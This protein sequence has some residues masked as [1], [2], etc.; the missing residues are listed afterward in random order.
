MPSGG[1]EH[2]WTAAWHSD[3]D[4]GQYRD[5]GTADH[6]RLLALKDN[7]TGR[8]A[9]MAAKLRAA[10]A[11]L[12]GKTN[13]SEWAN[14][15]STRS[16]SGWSAVGGLVKNP[17]ALDRNA[18]GSS[19]GTGAAAAASLAAAGVGTETSGS[20]VCPA[21]VNGL[22]G[23]KPTVGLVSREHVVPISH[24]Q[25]TPGPMARTVMDAALVLTGMAGSDAADL[26]TAE[27]D[28]R[29]LNYV[30]ALNRQALR[31]KRLGVLKIGMG[32]TLET[33]GLFEQAQKDLAAAGAD[34]RRGETAGRSRARRRRR[35]DFHYAGG[36]QGRRRQVSLAG[37]AR[38]DGK[39]A[40]RPDRLQ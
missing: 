25:D 10:G 21:N 5:E 17:Y 36:V 37:G 35:R 15:R 12:L 1:R 28:H 40:R 14:F 24:T 2:P 39:D 34:A 23:F 19:S 27:A 16:I 26:A 20:I 29:K 4:Q 13:L 32:G 30:A 9:P 18:C 6:S 11:I 22:V 8:D 31:G 38:R 3:S 7:I 33:D